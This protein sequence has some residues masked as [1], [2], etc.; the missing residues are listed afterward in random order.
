MGNKKNRQLL[1]WRGLSKN[2]TTVLKAVGIA[3][4][5]LH[6]YFHLFPGWMI[7]NEFSFKRKNFVFFTSNFSLDLFNDFKLLFA[8]FGHYGVQLFVFLSAY[9]LYSSYS[10][11]QIHYGKFVWERIWKLWPAFFLAVL[12]F[13]AYTIITTRSFYHPDLYFGSL[14][15]LSFL[16]NFF[17][18]QSL[19]V[20]GP[21]WF[22]SMIVQ[23]YLLFPL[24]R[25][26]LDRYSLLPLIL[27]SLA[28]W[29]SV[30]VFIFKIKST[31][32]NPIALV[33]GHLPVFCLG[34]VLAKYKNLAMPFWLLIGACALFYLGNLN[35]QAWLF[36]QLSVTIILL[37]G[38][39]FLKAMANPGPGAFRNVLFFTGNLSMYLFA[40]NGFLRTP[41]IQQSEQYAS[42]GIKILI[43][44]VFLLFVTLVAL[45]L[46]LAE[47]GFLKLVPNPGYQ[48]IAGKNRRVETA[49]CDNAN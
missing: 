26:W 46:R 22:Y 19:A 33:V 4:I 10:G 30:Y 35:H 34:L 1:R 28:S 29:V 21:W 11:K 8:Y 49:V 40:V 3:A 31:G 13:L 9:G 43:L 17:P 20:V 7:E 6:N 5:V 25:K 16:S 47:K 38:Y 14:L 44:V 48:K 2:D 32:V 36:S 39:I 24:L 12:F 15:R 37:Y 41:F 18:R 45:L 42:V 27:L 23:F